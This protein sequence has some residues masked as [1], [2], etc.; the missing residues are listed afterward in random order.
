MDLQG[1]F[2]NVTLAKKEANGSIS[3]ACV[4]NADSAAAFLGIK[5]DLLGPVSKTA[6]E[7]FRIGRGNLENFL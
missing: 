2:Q 7:K 1:R 3:Q 4:N 6:P 5:R